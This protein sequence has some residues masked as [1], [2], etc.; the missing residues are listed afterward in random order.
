MGDEMNGLRL[1]AMPEELRS[2][3]SVFF[4]SWILATLTAKS[5]VA[6]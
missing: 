2:F 6:E 4:P 1:V 5:N 3:C